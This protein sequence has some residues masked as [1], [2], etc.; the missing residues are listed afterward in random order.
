MVV[1]NHSIDK[2]YFPVKCNS[3]E[4]TQVIVDVL[5]FTE[6]LNIDSHDWENGR[7]SPTPTIVEAAIALYRGHSVKEISRSDASAINLSKT[8]DTLAEIIKFTRDNSRKSI[9]FVTGVPGS[10]KTLV[11]L[12][13]ATTAYG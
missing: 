7:Y 12:N 2:L 13:I 5:E 3:G 10:G 6:G 1:T 11:G 9:C 8:S 4:L